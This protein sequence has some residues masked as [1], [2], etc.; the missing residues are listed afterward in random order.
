MRAYRAAGVEQVLH[1]GPRNHTLRGA[2][3]ALGG[4]VASSPAPRAIVVDFK[5]GFGSARRKDTSRCEKLSS[6]FFRHVRLSAYKTEAANEFRLTKRTLRLEIT[7]CALD[8][9]L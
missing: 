7:G 3:G 2:I 4:P 6:V 9:T 5:G 8:G 1:A